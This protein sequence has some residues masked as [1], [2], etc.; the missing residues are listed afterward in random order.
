MEVIIL[1]IIA[2]VVGTGTGGL[3][4]SF[5]G[6]TSDRMTSALLSFA[7]GVMIAIVCFGLIPEALLIS[8]L[9]VCIVGILLGVL[10]VLGLNR[11]VDKFTGAPA[12]IHETPE[13]LYHQSPVIRQKGLLKSGFIMLMAIGLHNIPEGLAIGSGGSYNLTLGLA[14]AVMI[15]LHN[16][17]EGMAIATPLIAGGLSRSRA[18][19][20]TTISGA[21]TIIGALLG[22][23]LGEISPTA[24]AL[25]LSGAGG[26]ML[27]VVFGEIIPQS[28]VLNKNRTPTMIALAGIVIGMVITLGGF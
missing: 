9:E 21:P 10:V 18:V 28:V 25:S 14:L 27:Y 11:A 3:I 24:I 20:L 2:G 12:P 16:I 19:F 13:E 7:S 15:A 22:M 23:L 5:L 1:S 6:N 4:A 8:G 17:P 26:A